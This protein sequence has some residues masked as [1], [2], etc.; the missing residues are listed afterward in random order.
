MRS[1]TGKHRMSVSSE[2]S[3]MPVKPGSFVYAS[4]APGV[5]EISLMRALSDS[6][7]MSEVCGVSVPS[8]FDPDVVMC[9]SCGDV[10]AES[11]D[12]SVFALC[13]GCCEKIR[14][15]TSVVMSG[16][17]E[18]PGLPGWSEMSEGDRMTAVWRD[19][20]EKFGYAMMDAELAKMFD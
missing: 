18:W 6:F 16:Q 17:S 1:Y 20:H 5:S 3:E 2:T 8:T 15:R 13:A 4:D 19:M 7:Y 12:E 10:P 9:A 11:R 14:W